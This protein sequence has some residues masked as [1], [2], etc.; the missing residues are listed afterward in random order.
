MVHLTREDFKEIDNIEVNLAKGFDL[1]L[2][3]SKRG[4]KYN[5]TVGPNGGASKQGSMF[6]RFSKAFV[7]K[8]FK[9]YNKIYDKINNLIDNEYIQV[10]L[11]ECSVLGRTSNVVNNTKNYRYYFPIGLVGNKESN[12]TIDDILV[13]AGENNKFYLKSKSLNKKLIFVKDNMLNTKL[14]STLY[15]LLYELSSTHEDVLLNRVFILEND[16]IYSPRV[17]FEDVIISLEKWSFSEAVLRRDM[18][19]NFKKDLK[20]LIDKYKIDK[21]VYLVESDNRLIIDVED[22]EDI[23]LLYGT[24]KKRGELKLSEVEPDIVENSLVKDEEF[25]FVNEFVFSL[26]LNESKDTLSKDLDLNLEIQNKHRIFLPFQDGWIYLKLY[27]L[28][29]RTDEFLTRHLNVLEEIGKPKWFF[30]RYGDE[31]GSHIRL[32]IKLKDEQEAISKLHIINKWISK[33]YKINIIKKVEFDTY[34]RE[35]NR[36]GGIELIEL[37]EEFSH[38]SSELVVETLRSFNIEETIEEIYF[39]EILNLF[40]SSTSSLD[41][42][43][44][45]IDEE[46]TRKQFRDEFKGRRKELMNIVEVLLKGEFGDFEIIRAS[47]EKMNLLLKEFNSKLDKCKNLGLLTNDKSKIIGSLGHMHCNRLTGD[48]T[49]ELKTF[50]MLR[51]TI[52]DFILKN[53]CFKEEL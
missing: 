12:L 34:E 35:S 51:H 29:N 23:N 7:E 4:D 11:R 25:T 15:Q 32:R 27:G 38:R 10:E 40:I 47:I 19:E 16:G 33:L 52:H 36:Y 43:I 31:E 20:I 53:R 9:E 41:E 5:L 24:Y 1:N 3:I 13:G 2:F 37:F 50:V 6:Q 42:L 48:R 18:V 26:V 8:D 49:L 17:Y 44:Y 39:F 14:N 22:D 30:I 45:L 21:M 46:N 28:E